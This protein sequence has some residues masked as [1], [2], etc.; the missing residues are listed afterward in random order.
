MEVPFD[1]SKSLA[2]L[3]RCKC[4]ASDKNMPIKYIVINR[5]MKIGNYAVNCH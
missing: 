3:C 5:T 4:A 2:V 1:Y